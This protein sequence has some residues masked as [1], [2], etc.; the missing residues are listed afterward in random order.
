[1]GREE[2]GS[3]EVEAVKDISV[4]LAGNW[5]FLDMIIKFDVEIRQ[6]TPQGQ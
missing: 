1:M 3:D 6:L 5:L 2:E 4:I